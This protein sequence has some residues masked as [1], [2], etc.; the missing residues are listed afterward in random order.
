MGELLYCVE[1]TFICCMKEKLNT[2]KTFVVCCGC[3]VLLL[4]DI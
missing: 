2:N 4:Y 1:D 3:F